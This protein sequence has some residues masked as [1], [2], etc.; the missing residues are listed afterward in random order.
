[1]KT[2]SALPLEQVGE[3]VVITPTNNLNEFA[4]E[5]IERDATHVLNLLEGGDVKNIVIDF[6]HT[7]YYGSTA[8]SFFVK[9]WKRVRHGG[10]NMAVCNLSEHEREILNITKLD[11]LWAICESR[12]DALSLVTS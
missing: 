2:T 1:M 9:L 12:D 7:D 8:L 6:S 4:F 10:G 11:S 5:Q 3:T